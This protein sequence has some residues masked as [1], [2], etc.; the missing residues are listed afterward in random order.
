MNKPLGSTADKEG[1]NCNKLSLTNF[2][3]DS[4]L[5]Y[6]FLQTEWKFIYDN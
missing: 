2:K 3:H 6:N 5:F 4:T 1:G